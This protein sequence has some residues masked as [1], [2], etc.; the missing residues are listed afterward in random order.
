MRTIF[1]FVFE[2][3]VYEAK[4]NGRQENCGDRGHVI[5]STLLSHCGGDRTY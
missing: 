5:V 3:Q 4:V 2:D 1:F